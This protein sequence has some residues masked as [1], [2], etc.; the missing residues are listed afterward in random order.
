MAPAPKYS[1]Q[2][3]LEMILDAA[4]ECIKASSVMDFTMAKVARTAGL[5]MGSVY[6]HVQS[7]EDIILALAHSSFLH[8]SKIFDQV[9]ALPITTPEKVLAISLIAPRKLQ[10]FVF[11]NDL[12]SYAVNEAVISRAS[13]I[14]TEK[15]IVANNA[16]E[17]SFKLAL[18]EGINSGELIGELNLSHA[19]EEIIL[20]SWAMCV[21]YDQ[22]QRVKQI[23]QIGEGTDSLMDPLIESDPIIRSSIRFLNSYPWQKPLTEESVKAL[24]YTLTDINLR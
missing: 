1:H 20:G 3:Q 19:I 7:K 9:L 16:C 15:M 23:K 21:G 6:K 13:N 2:K 22:V 17:Q 24:I 14:W 5:S 18:T 4:E 12:L 8:V 11:D 10:Y